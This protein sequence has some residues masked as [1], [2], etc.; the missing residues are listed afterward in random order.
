M[1]IK[2]RSCDGCGVEIEIQGPSAV[3]ASGWALLI[4]FGPLTSGII[5]HPVQRD[6]HYC[7]E[8]KAKIFAAVS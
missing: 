7:P 3:S 2:T 1:D 4:D 8:C 6:H 5:P